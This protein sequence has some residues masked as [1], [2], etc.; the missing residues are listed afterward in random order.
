[1]HAR[2]FV[3]T[4]AVM[5]LQNFLSLHSYSHSCPCKCGYGHKKLF[6][7]ALIFAHLHTHVWLCT[8]KVVCLCTHFCT[9]A[10]LHMHVRLCTYKVV[11]LSTLFCTLAQGCAVMHIQSCLSLHS[12]SHIC[13]CKCSYAHTQL[14]VF[15]LIFANL[16]M[17]VR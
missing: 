7:F 5:H 13:P 10:Q 16:H 9:I 2:T 14:F 1:M 11:C 3:Y 4:C 12:C 17:Y 8:C 15:A 6:V